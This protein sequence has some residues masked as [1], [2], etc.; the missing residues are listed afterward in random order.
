M[1]KQNKQNAG[2]KD[3][4][5]GLIEASTAP[6]LARPQTASVYGRKKEPITRI[7]DEELYAT[8]QSAFDKELNDLLALNQ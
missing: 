3:A 5:P 6:P 8:A 1:M 7:D 4:G 2:I